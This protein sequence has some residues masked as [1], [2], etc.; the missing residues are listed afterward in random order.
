[1]NGKEELIV[2]KMSEIEEPGHQ[3]REKIT[4][5]G[6]EELSRSLAKVG[7]I[8]PITLRKKDNHYEIVAGHRRYLAA[9]DLG[10]EQIKA[11]IREETDDDTRLKALHENLHREDMSPVE[12][13][14][15]IKELLD[16]F[17]ESKKNIARMCG[18][19]E[20]WVHGRID[21]LEMPSEL[22]EAVDV[23]ALSVGA[24]R[25]LA[26]IK[27][28]VALKYYTDYAIKQGATAALCAFWRSKWE[29][30]K[31]IH[32]STDQTPAGY[33][34]TPPPMEVTIP[35]FWCENETAIRLIN[36]IRV[37]PKCTESIIRT[38]QLL[39]QEAFEAAAESKAVSA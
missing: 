9:K 23:G 20:S 22:R 13:G 26:G 4:E 16:R 25:E 1:M 15:A 37:C 24:A 29:V 5:E 6:L 12:E 14:R 31:I 3:L 39:Q 27:D 18:K 36:H 7:L 11:I 38:K 35:C 34:L 21:L 30:E 8:N 10:W 28:D 2:V 19:S 17:G 33:P 32:Q